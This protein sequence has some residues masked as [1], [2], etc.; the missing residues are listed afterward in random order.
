MKMKYN[1]IVKSIF[2]L[3]TVLFLASCDRDFNTVGANFVGDE[4]FGLEH[5]QAGITTRNQ[6]TGA[7]QSNNLPVTYFGYYNN[8]AFGKTTASFATQLGLSVNNPTFY[9]LSTITVDSVYIYVPYYSH[10]TGSTDSNGDT[11]Y[12]LDNTYGIDKIKLSVHQLNYDIQAFGGATGNELTEGRRYFSDEQSN[13]EPNPQL[14]YSNDNFEFNANQ[15]KIKKNIGTAT[16]AVKE[17][18]APGMFLVLA[19]NTNAAMQSFFKQHFINSSA[20][21]HMANSSVFRNYFKGLFFKAEASP[22]STNNGTLAQLNFAQ[23]K[24][25]MVYKDQKSSTDTTQERKEM[26]LYLNGEDISFFNDQ[27]NNAI[28]NNSDTDLV[29]K[30]GNGSM[31]VV[32]LFD[33][34][35][36]RGYDENGNATNVPNGV[37]DELDDIRNPADS[38]KWL[39]NDASITFTIDKTKMGTTAPEPIRVY[40]YDLTN[41]KPLDDY[42]YDYTTNS[43]NSK[44]GKTIHDGIIQLG[45]DERGTKYRIRLTN[46]IRKIVKNLNANG[47]N[48]KLGLVV[49][50]NINTI[51]NYYFKT[52]FMD[53]FGTGK[54]WKTFPIMSVAN[55][56]GT[57]LYGSNA[58]VAEANRV[59]FD[60]WYTKPN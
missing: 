24:I 58:S 7:V 11:P 17:R 32:D 5:Y 48:V 33:S 12:A 47:A 4:H 53:Y 25:T 13:F 31:V 55:P 40:L 3:T 18:L 15:I 22:S 34:Q 20:Q 44:L 46:H 28:P 23:G 60:I 39:I 42:Y 54:H 16:E 14:I 49:T 19:D 8:P 59:K 45:S 2:T 41:N 52:P 56:L 1:A 51:S 26:T 29:L 21:G 6:V 10:T 36:I 35:D 57:Y 9:N 43:S 37:S 50:E 38:K 27:L 30:G